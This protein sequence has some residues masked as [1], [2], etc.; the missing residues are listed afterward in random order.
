MVGRRLE[1]TG[2]H[3]VSGKSPHRFPRPGSGG[4]SFRLVLFMTDSR[5]LEGRILESQARGRGFV[6][7]LATGCIHWRARVSVTSPRA[8]T[9]PPRGQAPG[10]TR[11]RPHLLSPCGVSR[12]FKTVSVLPLRSPLSP[13]GAG[14]PRRAW[15]A[16]LRESPWHVLITLGHDLHDLPVDRHGRIFPV[17]SGRP[18][19]HPEKQ[20]TLR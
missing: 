14:P 5:R 15:P 16:C 18:H 4:L 8:A 9:G 6:P 20:R 19:F 2:G 11:K 13:G 7:V 17:V 1:G 10:C 12:R 3:P